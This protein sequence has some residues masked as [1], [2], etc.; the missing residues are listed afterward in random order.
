MKNYLETFLKEFIDQRNINVDKEI[1]N[2]IYF[3]FLGDTEYT[4][5]KK[6][7]GNLD[8]ENNSIKKE[9]VFKNKNSEKD[10]E[11]EVMYQEQEEHK[12]NERDNNIIWISSYK[13]NKK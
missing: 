4:I 10:T 1:Y 9:M 8:I 12:D 11:N 7:I 3:E 6:I 13:K 5:D 2:T